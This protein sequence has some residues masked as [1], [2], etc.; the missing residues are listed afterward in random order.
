MSDNEK[1][2]A[3]I[4]KEI[5]YQEKRWG[6]Q[7]DDTKNRP[8]DW[9]SFIS[10]YSTRWFPGGYAPYQS[11]T[12]DAFRASMIKTASLAISAIKSLDRQRAKNG[13]AFYEVENL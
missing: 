1:I 10:H 5:D 2:F 12:V 3:E 9:A 6:T 8:N 4:V 13:A 7:S 11:M